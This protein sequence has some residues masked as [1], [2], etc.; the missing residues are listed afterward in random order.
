MWRAHTFTS[1][2]CDMLFETGFEAVTQEHSCYIRL[3]DNEVG[4]F[5][6]SWASNDP[7][8][9]IIS[10]NKEGQLKLSVN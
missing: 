2:K 6:Y 1:F 9:A 4:H 5:V 8:V 7:R 10:N 3:L